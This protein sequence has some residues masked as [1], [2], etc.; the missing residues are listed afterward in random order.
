[1]T[2]ILVASAGGSPGV[3]T[4]A[5]GLALLWPRDVLLAEVDPHPSQ[6]LLAG[7]LRGLAAGGRGLGGLAQS[8]RTQPENGPQQLAEQTLALTEQPGRRRCFLPGFTH[9]R[10][11]VL[12]ERYW[13]RLAGQLDDLG[14]IGTDAICDCGRLTADGLP[15][16]LLQHARAVL[17]LTRSDLPALA[18]LRLHLPE[19]A[20]ATQQTASDLLLGVVGAGRPYSGAEIARQL[21]LPLLA[22]LAWDPPTAATLRDG[23][24]SPKRLTERPLWRGLQTLSVRLATRATAGAPPAGPEPPIG[25]PGTPR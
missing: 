19:L 23:A 1:M 6:V 16:A 22:E 12:F 9:P 13:P 18:M 15:P 11:A 20:T 17:L 10:G 7:Y 24:P 25:L 4:T 14:R 3:T 21:E 5:L 2:V 8:Y